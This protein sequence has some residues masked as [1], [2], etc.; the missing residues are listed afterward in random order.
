MSVIAKRE[1]TFKKQSSLENFL[2]IVEKV[3]NKL[4]DPVT[5]F[6]ILCFST[7]LLSY[8]ARGIE[9]VNPANGK[10]IEV[11]NLLSK[12]NLRKIVME[13]VPEFQSFPPLGMVVIVTLGAGVAEK[14]GLLAAAMETSITKVPKGLITAAVIL[15]SILA[16]GAGDSG[17]VL[18]PPLAAA[19]F[20]SIGRHPL[21]G[22]FAAYAAVNAGFSANLIVNMTDV[23]VASFT[24]P[25]AKIV[26]SSYNGTPAMNIYFMI[27]STIVL[28]ILGVYITEKIIAPRFEKDK[29]KFNKNKA[30]KTKLNYTEKRAL[31]WSIISVLV[32]A[33][34]VIA[35]CIGDDAFFRDPKSGSLIAWESPLMQGLIPIITVMFLIP[36][37]I[38]G[39]MTGKIKSD[40]DA[41]NMMGEAMKDMS[42][43]LVI[44]CFASLFIA[45]FNWSNLGI[46]LA[47][48]GTN[49][50]KNSGLPG[51][52][53]IVGFI[54]LEALIN[55]LIGSASAKWAIMA[56]IFVPMLMFIGYSPAVT[57]MAFRIG[58]S[59]TNPI[60]PL[61][62]YFPM[63][64]VLM[65]K[66]DKEAGMG[67]I[68]SSMLP[69]SVLFGIVW[70]ALLIL[71]IALN[72]PLGPGDGIKYLLP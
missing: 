37:L 47:V 45:L 64:L 13:Y 3:G 29:N 48:K 5:L 8:V 14:S 7:L 68:I 41:V 39:K 10:S 56:P 50:L 49:L 16:D 51:I 67:T 30:Q 38:Y 57:Q 2:D 4:P 21:V 62:A 18:L 70:T 65:K 31:K 40:K 28:T 1:K 33:S 22:M 54:I 15:I 55:I 42:S 63:M 11:V 6:V 44:A 24:I 12:T 19:T 72:I 36:G 60:S 69:Y 61:G 43:F 25:A 20:L 58:D 27:V 66:Y 9:V 53:I 26:D 23:L 17:F 32:I 35:L 46:V 59:I 34:I 52:L 71:F